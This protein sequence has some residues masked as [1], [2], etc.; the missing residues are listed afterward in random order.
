MSKGKLNT[1][2]IESSID[3]HY[4]RKRIILNEN[5]RFKVNNIANEISNKN[6]PYDALCWALA[7]FQIIYE[8]GKGNFSDQDVID[9]AKKLFNSSLSYEGV[10]WLI[11]I[12]KVYLEEV[13]LYP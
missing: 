8:K 7:E 5:L 1:S 11:S 6:Y 10:C 12:L 4:F 9:R 13:K 3:E 2:L